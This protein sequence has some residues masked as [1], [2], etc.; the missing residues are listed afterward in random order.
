LWQYPGAFCTKVVS[1][2]ICKFADLPTQHEPFF[3]LVRRP[4]D[5]SSSG[6]LDDTNL[7]E[8][9]AAKN[10]STA[11]HSTVI[12]VTALLSQETGD[13][14]QE[15]VVELPVDDDCV[16][17]P[18]PAG[19]SKDVVELSS[20][21]STGGKGIGKGKGQEEAVPS[22][23]S[24]GRQATVAAPP[25]KRASE[26]QSKADPPAKKKQTRTPTKKPVS[27]TVTPKDQHNYLWK[28]HRNNCASIACPLAVNDQRAALQL[29]TI[30]PDKPTTGDIMGKQV[31][32]TKEFIAMFARKGTVIGQ[33]ESAFPPVHLARQEIRRIGDYGQSLFRYFMQGSGITES[34]CGENSNS[35]SNSHGGA[36][37]NFSLNSRSLRAASLFVERDILGEMTA[38]VASAVEEMEVEAV[39]VSDSNDSV[40]EAHNVEV[41]GSD[42]EED[43]SIRVVD[44]ESAGSAS[45]DTSLSES[46]DVE[47]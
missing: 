24:E 14:L 17:V 20:P 47:L 21:P 3:D 36:S 19:T 23:T 4:A 6:S 1:S 28:S 42:D 37:E 32:S 18:A 45:S 16:E 34:F 9:E 7:A 5:S 22:K 35:H 31:L 30:L 39:S 27:S 40:G 8:T 46:G 33:D 2:E 13:A 43:L 12:P 25:K 41:G 44:L 10:A 26:G 29:S 15:E 11:T 38:A